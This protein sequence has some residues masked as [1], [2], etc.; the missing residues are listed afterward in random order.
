MT[1][2]WNEGKAQDAAAQEEGTTCRVVI[3]LTHEEE[4]IVVCRTWRWF[5]SVLWSSLLLQRQEPGWQSMMGL[6]V[7]LSS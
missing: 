2:T 7:E 4:A 5:V 6:L 1:L 3:H